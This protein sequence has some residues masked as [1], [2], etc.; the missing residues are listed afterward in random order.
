M[1]FLLMLSY[2]IH[3]LSANCVVICIYHLLCKQIGRVYVY[4]Y[5]YHMNLSHDKLWLKQVGGTSHLLFTDCGN[6]F[7]CV[8]FCYWL[9]NLLKLWTIIEDISFFRQLLLIHLYNFWAFCSCSLPAISRK[10]A[11]YFLMF[12]S[13]IT[14]HASYKTQL[15]HFL[16]TMHNS[17]L[18][19]K[20]FVLHEGARPLAY[21]HSIKERG[22][23]FT[24]WLLSSRFLLLK[25]K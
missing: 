2:L 23:V 20:A 11:S 10:H 8:L 17:V 25:L 21:C 18:Q 6:G 15:W 24:E 4:I 1:S 19:W 13:H 22:Q 12:F 7:V 9:L 16:S 3:I 5:I 14:S